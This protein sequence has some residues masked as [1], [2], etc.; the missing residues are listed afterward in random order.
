MKRL[1]ILAS[2]VCVLSSGAYC[3]VVQHDVMVPMRDGVHLATD[4]HL[5]AKDGKTLDGK[6]P[7]ILWRT[8][9]NKVTQGQGAQRYTRYGYVV[10][11]QDVRGRFASE[12][13]WRML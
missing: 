4:I 10:V 6:F 1:L 3:Q 9:Y 5:P 7:A 13:H 8:P 2:V 11:T 12:G